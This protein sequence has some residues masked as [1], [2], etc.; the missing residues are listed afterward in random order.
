MGSNPAIESLHTFT[1]GKWLELELA[2]CTSQS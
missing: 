2:A 1:P